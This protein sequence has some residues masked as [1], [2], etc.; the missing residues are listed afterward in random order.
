MS[1][2]MN[3]TK[4]LNDIERFYLLL[5]QL[6]NIVGGTRKLKDCNGRMDWPARGVYFFYEN[7]EVRSNSGA[8]LRV[9]R[10][11]THALKFGSSTT[12]WTRLRQHRG[13]IGGAQPGGG[14]HRGSVFRH[15]VGTALIN[16]DDW[17]DDIT[18]QWEVG[19]NAPREI[20]EAEYPLE[21]VVSECICNMPFLWL[22]IDDPPEPDSMR[23]YLE[24]NSIGLLS[25]ITTDKPIDPASNNWLGQYA[26]SGE[27][28]SSGLWNVNHV[29]EGYKSRFLDVL[30]N[31]IL[32]EN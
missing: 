17:S 10:I 15:H 30:E 1:D 11:G 21:K 9:V 26:K 5:G 28:R 23:G 19:N 32:T 24:R 27:V 13:T 14:N 16:R 7:G 4:R 2:P 31:I 29:T 20:R 25:N 18:G 22:E 3:F 6:E 12:L 8:G